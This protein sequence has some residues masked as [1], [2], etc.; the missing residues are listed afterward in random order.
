L[1]RKKCRMVIREADII[2]IPERKL[3]TRLQVRPLRV[4]VFSMTSS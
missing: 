3:P 2:P 4:S 1:A